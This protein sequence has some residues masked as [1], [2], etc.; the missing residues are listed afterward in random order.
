MNWVLLLKAA[1]W[2]LISI[3]ITL[4]ITYLYTGKAG[5]SITLT[6]IL[7]VVLTACQ[8]GYEK[9]WLKYF[10]IRI[11]KLFEAYKSTT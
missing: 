7:T 9:L 6:A 8:F 11:K 10:E 3:P 1:S 2:R 4:L 5:G